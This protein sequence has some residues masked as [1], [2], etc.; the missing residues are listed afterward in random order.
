MSG[1]GVFR[2][3]T[4]SATKRRTL[5]TPKSLGW[6]MPAEWA[7][8]ETTHLIFPHMLTNWRLEAKPAQMRQA[9]VAR[10]IAEFEPVTMW[11]EEKTEKAAREAL[12]DVPNVIFKTMASD[13]CWVR[14]SGPTFLVKQDGATGNTLLGGVCWD[15][16]GW[17]GAHYKPKHDLFV[18]THILRDAVQVSDNMFSTPHFVLEGGSI[19]VDGEGTILATEEC[20]CNPNRNPHLSKDEIEWYLKEYLG[21]DK[22]VWLPRGLT[23][24]SDTNGH[25]DNFCVFISPANV[26]LAWCEDP[27]DKQYEISRE[28]YDVLTQAVDAQGRKLT[29]HKMVTPPPMYY[30]EEYCEQLT[31]YWYSKLFGGGRQPGQR[32]AASYINFLTCNGGIVAPA[33]NA[34]TDE[35]AREILQ[36]CFPT[37][38]I[39]MVDTRELLYGGGNIHCQTQQQPAVN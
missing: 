1:V 3:F 15:F 29:I 18:A 4:S 17:G 28:A 32:M 9:A 38:K 10:A 36:K 27:T 39:V 33:F 16:N 21:G 8:H 34:P 24:D 20:L 12:D 31:G 25:V 37:R 6:T 14:D 30:T 11:I 23:D 35:L 22:V 7:P 5:P 19:H 13:D 26:L 2:W